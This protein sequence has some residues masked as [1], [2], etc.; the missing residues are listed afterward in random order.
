[1]GGLSERYLDM[2]AP[3]AKQKL[4]LEAQARHV[5][6]GG[7]RGGG[8]SWG[9]RTKAIMLCLKQPGISVLIVRQS[10]PELFR[11]HIE[12]L[13][14]ALFGLARYVD[15]DKII[16]FPNGSTISF[17]YCSRDADLDILQ[18]AE[19]DVVFVDEAT[20]LTEYQLKALAAVN[21]GVNRFPK[22]MYYTCNPG[23]RGHAYIKRLFIDRNFNLDEDPG[24]Y[25][26]IQS[27]L[28]DNKIL[29]KMDPNYVKHL[30]ALPHKLKEAWLYGKWDVFSGQVFTEWTDNRDG[31]DTHAGTHVISGDYEVPRHY[32]IIR[33]F[34]W[35]Y[36]K[37]AAVLWCAVDEQRRYY[38]V[39]ELY[40]WTGEPDVGIQWDPATIA[41]KIRE[42][43]ADDP[44]LRGRVIRG[45]ADP[46][47]YKEDGGPS[48]AALM[49]RERVVFSPG[50]NSR[51][52]GKMQLHYRLRFD[53][54]G[55]P[56]LYVVETC[57]NMIRT[58]PM[59]IYS[60]RDAEDVDT[61]QEDHLYDA[62][63]YA[64]MENALS[65]PI[66]EP[67]RRP[68]DDPLGLY[69]RDDPMQ[70]WLQD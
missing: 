8:K 18:G 64:I 43:E 56:M 50:D 52:A 1:M 5:A 27:L 47:I 53:E 40:C 15:K 45:V 34:D 30:E 4:F 21:R 10:Y 2:A 68:G 63:R 16:R 44:N 48:I 28:M 49:E 65:A 58:L 3:N 37:P 11:N 25:V 41:R 66:A 61:R 9:V 54:Y 69:D 6:F 13:R 38:V 32:R 14:L 59:L 57:V 12:Q 22:R 26:F 55:I 33:S 70:R 29:M 24:D 67:K 31:Y 7:A 19:F 23:G 20:Q 42:I 39:R 17:V 35:G 46:S 60:E 51:K 62:L 36:A